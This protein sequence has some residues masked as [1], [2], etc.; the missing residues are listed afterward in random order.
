LIVLKSKS[1]RDVVETVAWR[2]VVRSTSLEEVRMV[3]MGV[4]A[5]ALSLELVPE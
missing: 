4:V 5:E 1:L 2:F 3:A